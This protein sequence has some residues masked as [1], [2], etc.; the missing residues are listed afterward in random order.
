MF[1]LNETQTLLVNAC[2]DLSKRELAPFAHHVDTSHTFPQE[3]VNKMSAMG[4]MGMLVKEE[5]G[6]SGLDTFSYVLALEEISKGCASCGVIMSVN[7]SLYGAP[8]AKRATKEQRDKFLSKFAQGEKLGCFALTEPG[9]GSDAAAANTTAKKDGNHYILNGTKSW[10]TNGYEADAA[11][12]FATTDK[13]LKHRG[14]SAFLIPMPTQ[15]LTLGK[16]EQKLGI[17][18]SSTCNIIL[19]SCRIPS[20]YLLGKEGD[21]F[22]IAMETLD[23][24]RIGIAAQ[25]LGIASAA[26]EVS[27]RYAQE[28]V[29]FNKPI[30][31][32]Q[33]IQDK[34]ANMALRIE[35]SRL[36]TWKAALLKDGK[37]DF[38][39]LSAMA[40]LS[41]SETATFVSHQAIQILGGNGYVEDYPVERY[42]RDARITEIYEGTSEIQKLVIAG[43]VLKE[44]TI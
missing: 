4:L 29:A 3:Q 41:A 11:L 37:K 15:G 2:R 43:K 33:L 19:E 27:V 6:G 16:K 1:T 40:K 25:A 18:G 5:F 35:Q 44:L 7:N 24:G 36:I 23:G 34:I 38:T 9:N 12:V 14:I 13:S 42:Y 30:S 22:K 10:I 17:R 26:L 31:S 20:S 21:G 32:F 28:R 39:K 8:V